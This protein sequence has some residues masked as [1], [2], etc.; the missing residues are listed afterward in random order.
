MVAPPESFE[1]ALEA[2]RAGHGDA[3]P[4][5]RP[6]LELTRDGA[7]LTA[8]ARNRSLA[9]ERFSPDIAA[10]LPGEA[11]GAFDPVL[12]ATTSFGRSALQRG[13]TD[14]QASVR[15]TQDASVELTQPTAVGPEF[16][17]SGGLER[18]SDS[19]RDRQE[20][21]DAEV[22]LNAPLLRGAGSRV[23]LIDLR[24]AENQAAAS[25][26]ELRGFIN[27]LVAQVEAAYWELALAEETVRIRLASLELAREQERFNRDLFEVG[28]ALEGD[29]L[30]AQAEAAARE[31]DL[32]DARAERRQRVLDLLR[33]LSPEAPA[34][35]D[36]EIRLLDPVEV[37][38]VAV[39]PFE[40]L[41][42]AL[43]YRAELAQARLDFS[44]SELEVL[45]TR[46]GLLP[47]L[48]GFASY[49]RNA[50]GDDFRDAFDTARE[51]DSEG[52]R[53]GVAFETALYRRGERARLRRAQFQEAQAREAIRNL[54]ELLHLEV[55]QAVIEVERQWE[56]LAASEKAVEGRTEQL[57][58]AVDRAEAGLLSTL[59]AVQIQ[60][61]FVEAQ[62][63]LAT[64]RVRYIQALTELYRREGALAERRGIAAG[65]S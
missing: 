6:V 51:R 25:M 64:T 21:L 28:S 58:I 26:A 11:L 7:I 54:E 55:R 19:G 15:R 16:F 32:A 14:T 63:D 18:R 35:W 34:D 65:G 9:V 57:R 30:T 12:G 8:L 56:R 41:G 44:N 31:A 50:V 22:G 38:P 43:A 62:V 20:F 49:S 36:S 45:R 23:G 27:D 48:D 2:A 40:S 29:V 37:A 10:T 5:D 3:F 61:D 39:A 53:T 1:L 46:N 17:L 52:Y 60:R 59:D 42:L 47:R 4:G 33:L 13:P 24:Q